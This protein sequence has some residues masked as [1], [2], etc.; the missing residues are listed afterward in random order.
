AKAGQTHCPLQSLRV[1]PFAYVVGNVV[2]NGERLDDVGVRLKGS[3]SYQ[4]LTGKPSWKIRFDEYVEDQHFAGLSRVTLN[5]MVSDPAQSREVLGYALSRSAGLFAPRANFARVSVNGVV[6][7]LYTNLESMDEQLVAR[8]YADAA[9]DLW[10]GNDYADLTPDGVTHFE[11]VAG[12]GDYAALDAAVATLGSAPADTFLEQ[13]DTVLDMA[14]FLDLWAYSIAIG[15]R[16][17]YPYYVNDYFLYRDPADGRLDFSPWG[18]DES[19][20]TG[21][22]WNATY[23]AVG[24]ACLADEDCVAALYTRTSDALRAYEAMDYATLAPNLWVLT[25]PVLAEATRGDTGQSV[26]DARTDLLTRLSDWFTRVRL[27]MGLV[28]E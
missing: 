17:G 15:N 9:G 2:V 25:E 11:L 12:R 4:D 24:N 22:V 18:I 27:E 16:D 3:A 6:F 21:M 26:L 1:E 8:H 20:D 13:A 5:N 7:G 19:W 23:G 28:G 14:S 10:E